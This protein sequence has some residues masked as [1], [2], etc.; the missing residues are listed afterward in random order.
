M[1]LK[2]LLWGS[3]SSGFAL[4][5]VVRTLVMYLLLILLLKSTGKRGVRQLSMFEMVMIIALGSAAG[6][7]M[8]Y[9][10]VGL[11]SA[12]LVFLVIITVYR[13]IIATVTYSEK[14]EFL[15]EG[16]PEYIIKDGIATHGSAGSKNLGVDEFFAELRTSNVEHLGQVEHVL[17]ET[18]GTVSILFRPEEE[19]VFGL[20][21]W[22]A[23]YY[24]RTENPERGV[25][26]SCSECANT[27][28]MAPE[29][30][31]TCT[32]CGNKHWVKSLNTPR[33]S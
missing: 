23:V 8:L 33:R 25:H 17:L 9:K 2:E 28:L 12:T 27:L 26:Q 29:T 14:A 3:E 31:T 1:E 10:D 6:D 11:L 16:K 15:F 24:T 4:E 18:S 20:P 19:V 21:I 7:P 5:I 22:P 30:S 32:V 13:L